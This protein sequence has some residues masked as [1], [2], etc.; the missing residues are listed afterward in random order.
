LKKKEGQKKGLSITEL[1]KHGELL[2]EKFTP[3]LILST[4]LSEKKKGKMN[5]NLTEEKNPP[6]E[7]EKIERDQPGGEGRG[8]QIFTGIEV[9][10]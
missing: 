6:S 5:R 4:P 3:I 1:Q 9:P 10:R 7:G 2:Q 8:K